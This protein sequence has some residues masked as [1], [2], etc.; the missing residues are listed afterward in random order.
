LHDGISL[1]KRGIPTVVIVSEPFIG[2]ANVMAR[3][4]GIPDYR[5]IALPHPISSLDRKGID[6]LVRRC[7]P[8]VLELLLARPTA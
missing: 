7:F 5:Y 1:E 4:L 3:L 8:Q 6:E 2:N